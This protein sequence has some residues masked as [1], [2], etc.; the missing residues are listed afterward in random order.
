MY[1]FIENKVTHWTST[2]DFHFV[3]KKD[4]ENRTCASP[5]VQS[6]QTWKYGVSGNY[7]HFDTTTL[8]PFKSTAAKPELHGLIDLVKVT[9]RFSFDKPGPIGTHNRQINHIVKYFWEECWND[10]CPPLDSVVVFVWWTLGMDGRRRDALLCAIWT[11]KT[12]A[13]ATH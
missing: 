1:T 7:A 4:L 12:D 11:T 10:L 3:K 2:E 13:N 5:A 8:I 9:A 6:K